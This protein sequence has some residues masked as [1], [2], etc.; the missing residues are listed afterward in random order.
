VTGRTEWKGLPLS[1]LRRALIDVVKREG[2]LE[3]ET[4]VRLASGDWS[5]HFVDA[6]RALA[7][8]GDVNLAAEAI[9]ELMTEHGIEFDAVGGLTMGADVLAHGVASS[10]G[11]GGRWFSVRK[12]K[13]DRGTQQR[14]EGGLLKPGHR[15]LLVDDVV[16]RGDSIRDALNAIRETGADVVCAVTLID[17][18]EFG[19]EV[20]R[21]EG[22]PYF[23]LMSYRDIGIPAVGS[24]P[25]LASAAG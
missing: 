1:E 6:K 11:R 16:T 2:H 21:Q 4:P 25:G 17:R 10:I 7:D 24:E 8:G 13:K 15:V 14:I 9:R 18:G 5:R 23:R 3:F 19:A 12:V 20:F 22:V